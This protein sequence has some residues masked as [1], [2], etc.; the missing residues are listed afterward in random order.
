MLTFVNGLSAHSDIADAL[1]K[2][3]EPL[4]DVQ[5]YCP[6]PVQF[7]YVVVSTKGI[8]FGLAAGMNQVA[9]RLNPLF[10]DDWPEVDLT[11][12]ARKAY[13]LARES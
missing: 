5:T 1:L 4:G 13:V 7:K 6:D 2:S 9:F 8:I 11:F 3:V 10:R 12:W